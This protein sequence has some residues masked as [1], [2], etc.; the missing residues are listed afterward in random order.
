MKVF[1]DVCRISFSLVGWVDS[2]RGGPVLISGLAQFEI[3]PLDHA[4]GLSI[5]RASA[6]RIPPLCADSCE[7]AGTA[8]VQI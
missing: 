7:S 5:A 3:R 8:V 2:H 4:P 1:M 6:L